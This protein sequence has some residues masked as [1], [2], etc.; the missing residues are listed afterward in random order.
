MG[1]SDEK[2]PHAVIWRRHRPKAYR[3]STFSDR[4]AA[5]RKIRELSRQKSV[6]EIY[7]VCRIR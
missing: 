4:P 7:L 6:A 1:R 2:L 5:M 3:K